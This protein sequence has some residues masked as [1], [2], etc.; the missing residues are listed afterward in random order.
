MPNYAV[1]YIVIYNHPHSHHPHV[2]FYSH[3]PQSILFHVV[4]DVIPLQ[5]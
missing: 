3:H 1:Q 2:N 5:K 4:F